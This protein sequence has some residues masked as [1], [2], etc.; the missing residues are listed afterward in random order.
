MG[1]YDK[2]SS[3]S[4]V[5]LGKTLRSSRRISGVGGK[6]Y[7]MKE[8]ETM[9]REVFGPKF[10][11]NISRQDY[12]R[13]LAGLKRSRSKMTTDEERKTLDQKIDHLKDLGGRNV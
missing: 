12:R 3:I 13:A 2:K 5:E 10:G 8:V 9:H 1:I 11:S 6:R 4:R 7:T